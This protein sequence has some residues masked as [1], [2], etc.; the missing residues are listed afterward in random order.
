MNDQR[1]NIKN[2]ISAQ[3]TVF[4]RPLPRRW[5]HH[6]QMSLWPPVAFR[7]LPQLSFQLSR[8]EGN[9]NSNTFILSM[10]DMFHGKR[11]DPP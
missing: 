10:M 6:F 2:H 4:W 3:S 1:F 11:V 8:T 9:R 7:A 5:P